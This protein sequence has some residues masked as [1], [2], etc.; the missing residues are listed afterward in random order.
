VRAR[1]RLDAM[2]REQVIGDLDATER[3]ALAMIENHRRELES[4][5]R[6]RDE[7]QAALDKAEAAKHDRDRDLANALEALDERRRRTVSS[8]KKGIAAPA[9]RETPLRSHP[10]LREA[11]RRGKASLCPGFRTL[12]PGRGRAGTGQEY[13]PS[14]SDARNSAIGRIVTPVCR[15]R[16]GSRLTQRY[17]FSVVSS[18][19]ARSDRRSFGPTVALALSST[20]V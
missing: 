10:T 6:R 12:A 4:L 1:V 19:R 20:A 7:A 11:P 15:R 18:A 13:S 9:E 5:A 16:R 14:Q 3:R 17:R 8:R 2:M